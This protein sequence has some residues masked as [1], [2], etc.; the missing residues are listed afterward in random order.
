M[1]IDDRKIDR[2]VL[3]PVALKHR[4]ILKCDPDKWADDEV[5]DIIRDCGPQWRTM[6][7]Q[8]VRNQCVTLRK[9]GLLGKVGEPVQCNGS[10]GEA[11]HKPQ[12]LSFVDVAESSNVI[13]KLSDM[14]LD[15]KWQRQCL[16]TPECAA[17]ALSR[18]I[19]NRR[20]RK[21][22][23]NYLVRQIKE[24][25][26]QSDHPS[27]IVF[28]DAG[29]LLDGQ[30]R[31]QSI[32][33]SGE[34]VVA[35]CVGGARDEIREYIDTGVPRSM[36]DRM[37]FHP[38]HQ[39]NHQCAR[40]VSALYTVNYFR[41][42]DLGNYPNCKATPTEAMNLFDRHREAITHVAEKWT[43]SIKGV[44]QSPVMAAFVA[45]YEK[46]PIA[47]DEFWESLHSIDGRIQPARYLRNWLLQYTGPSRGSS[48]VVD[49]YAK[50]I[51]AMKA[52]LEGRDIIKIFAAKPPE[53]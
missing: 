19:G 20:L 38:D 47:C 49:L 4:A 33:V 1:P 9:A 32:V 30:H 29:R 39:A 40:L 53:L 48:R 51:Y 44:N 15:Q 14:P 34:S 8:N 52:Y 6:P 36:D 46:D 26:W 18:N 27:P 7:V 17:M 45:M 24:G 5:Q 41:G 23:V 42:K 12:S 21:A 11:N 31:I 2:E 43:S 50:T 28:S 3:L 13:P 10:H 22:S 37:G 35:N 25:E 16:I